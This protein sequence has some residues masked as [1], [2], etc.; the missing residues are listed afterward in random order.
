MIE[1]LSLQ[2]FGRFVRASMIDQEGPQH[3][4]DYFVCRSCIFIE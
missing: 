2:D 3:K 1:A 4:Y